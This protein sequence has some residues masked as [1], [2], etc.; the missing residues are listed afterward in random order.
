MVWL[1]GDPLLLCV[2]QMNCLEV[3]VAPTDLHVRGPD[4]Y[5]LSLAMPNPMVVGTAVVGADWLVL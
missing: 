1:L 2:L 3:R 5:S 4:L